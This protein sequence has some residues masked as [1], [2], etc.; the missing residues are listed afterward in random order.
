[1]ATWGHPAEAAAEPWYPCTPTRRVQ[2]GR[3]RGGR[4]DDP[5]PLR[6]TDLGR[7]WHRDFHYPRGVVPL[8][9]ALVTDLVRGAQRAARSPRLTASGGL[10]ARFVGPYVYLGAVPADPPAPQE[11]AVAFA[12]ARAYPARFRRQWARARGRLEARLR[13]LEDAPVERLD[14]PGL[15]AYLGRARRLHAHAWRLHFAVMYRLLASHEVIGGDLAALGME[16][17]ELLRNLQAGET[18]VLAAD[19][20]LVALADRAWDGGL[21]PMLTDH[22]PPALPRLAGRAEAGEWLAAFAGFLAVHGQRSD[23]LGD[24]TAPSWAED[25]EQPLALI[26]A[27]LTGQP[28][29]GARRTGPGRADGPDP[30]EP[31]R[32]RSPTR[33]RQDHTPT[34]RTTTDPAMVGAWTAATAVNFAWWNEDHNLVIDLRAHLPIRRAALALAAATHA[35]DRDAVLF[36]FAGEAGGLAAGE[37]G[38]RELAGRV[39]ARRAYYQRWGARRADLPALLGPATAPADPVI[40]EIISAGNV[41]RVPATGGPLTLTGLGVS[42]GLARG[43]VRIVHSPD[44]LPTIGPGTVLVCPATSPSWTPVFGLLAACVCDSGGMLTHAATIS[45]EYGI[46]CVCDA[47]WATSDLRDG[48]EVEV[49]GTAGTVVLTARAAP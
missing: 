18:S 25:P 31:P 42:G 30:H 6:P 2:T 32:G 14:L 39:A 4:F 36:L 22:P 35:P 26:R 13:D 49:D 16:Q 20:A 28:G 43:R 37:A 11:R 5:V 47:R 12:E 34:V 3:A 24:L 21:A 1:M 9:V 27:L 7:S 33:R 15:A 44:Q 23:T 46:P 41:A 19:H 10:A 45:R 40:R 38:W 8:G 48:D 17:A 29:R